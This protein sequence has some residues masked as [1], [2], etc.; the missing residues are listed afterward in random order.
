MK[1]PLPL[2]VLARTKTALP[3]TRS[4]ILA[5]PESLYFAF[6]FVVIPE[7]NL[8]LSSLLLVSR[9]HPEQREGPPQ[10]AVAFAYSTGPP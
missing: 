10:F 5:K 2:S 7:E 3:L 8:L 4:V 1:Q 6:A 9:P